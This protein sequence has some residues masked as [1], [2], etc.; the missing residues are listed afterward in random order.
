MHKKFSSKHHKNVIQRKLSRKFRFFNHPN[1]PF[2]LAKEA[3]LSY[4]AGTTTRFRL[5]PTKTLHGV[6]LWAIPRFH[7][8]EISPDKTETGVEWVSRL[9]TYSFPLNQD[10]EA[11][12]K[13][14]ANQPDQA[15]TCH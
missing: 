2:G 12:R 1:R 9:K 7:R 6:T 14:P 11:K 4:D 13:S 3:I 15:E 5:M 10:D 8:S